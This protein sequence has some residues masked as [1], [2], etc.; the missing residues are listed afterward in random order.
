MKTATIITSIF[1]LVL[2]NSCSHEGDKT[3]LPGYLESESI[4]VSSSQSGFLKTLS[5]SRGQQVEPDEM[6]FAI[7]GEV[8]LRNLN[9]A[10]SQLASIDA[11]IADAKKGQRAEEIAVLEAQIEEAKHNQIYAQTEFNRASRLRETN[12]IT[13]AKYDAAATQAK[14]TAARLKTLQNQLE[15]AKMGQRSDWIHALELEREGLAEQERLAEWK[16]KQCNQFSP[17]SALVQDTIF[18]PG[19]LVPAGTPVVVLRPLDTLLV[20][21]YVPNGQLAEAEVGKDIQIDIESL[22]TPLTATI[23]FVS[24][25]AEYTPPVIFSRE[26]TSDLVF[27]VEAEISGPTAGKLHPGMPV[28]VTL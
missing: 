8:E 19:E 14:T 5:V 11:Q 9:L 26:L 6:L 24:S 7:D 20:I 16:L 23:R 10:T 18:E 12:T 2:L 15:V 1:A 3:T 22:E 28:Q 17:I 4:Y 25:Q 13:E 21:F 27:R